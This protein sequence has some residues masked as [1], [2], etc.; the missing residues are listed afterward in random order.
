MLGLRVGTG[1]DLGHGFSLLWIRKP[2]PYGF[3]SN[4]HKEA[5]IARA[6]PFVRWSLG[7][8]AALVADLF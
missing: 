8:V 6:V 3:Q 4:A 7:V 1:L 5:S 2:F